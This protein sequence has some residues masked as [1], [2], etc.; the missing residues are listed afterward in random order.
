MPEYPC[1]VI[2]MAAVGYFVAVC[3][4]LAVNTGQW[5]FDVVLTSYFFY[6]QRIVVLFVTFYPNTYTTNSPS[7]DVTSVLS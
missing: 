6:S 1:S 4:V 5:L 7:D 2:F 3:I